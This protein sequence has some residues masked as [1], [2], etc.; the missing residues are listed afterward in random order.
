MSINVWERG[1]SNSG[2]VSGGG[3]V[4]AVVASAGAEVH[5]GAGV[6]ALGSCLTLRSPSPRFCVV[7]VCRS[8]L[9]R[10]I[11]MAAQ[12][13]TTNF[14]PTPLTSSLARSRMYGS[15]TSDGFVCF[16]PGFH[17]TALPPAPRRKVT[18]LDA[19]T[20]S[21]V[22]RMARTVMG[23]AWQVSLQSSHSGG[24]EARRLTDARV[25]PVTKIE[26]AKKRGVGL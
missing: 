19:T 11:C 14:A 9:S 21:N 17:L 22:T 25:R 18:T 7:A 8:P 16:A 13:F 15:P 20:S 5:D 26:E 1:V 2:G 10:S 23:R 4:E 12:S 3:E 24:L 6:G